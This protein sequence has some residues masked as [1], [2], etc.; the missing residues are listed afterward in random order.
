M[1]LFFL[2]SVLQNMHIEHTKFK[3][4]KDFETEERKIQVETD[5]L[6]KVCNCKQF[7]YLLIAFCV[8]QK[9]NQFN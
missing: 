8:M 9:R 2:V 4:K 5:K 6:K 1:Y 7:A 3:F